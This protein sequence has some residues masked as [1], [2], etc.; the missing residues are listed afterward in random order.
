V[1]FH[2]TFPLVSGTM[3]LSASSPSGSPWIFATRCGGSCDINLV[4]SLTV[5]LY[6]IISSSFG[7][8]GVP[9]TGVAVGEATGGDFDAF[10]GGGGGGG[11]ARRICCCLWRDS[12]NDDM[13]S[14]FCS[15]SELKDAVSEVVS[16]SF[17][18]SPLSN[19]KSIGT[20]AG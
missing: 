15:T 19:L 10:V 9:T 16:G 4:S 13:R 11:A 7:W 5:S 3:E 18:Q 17:C 6:S 14:S 20:S 12:S 8:L 2:T 1:P